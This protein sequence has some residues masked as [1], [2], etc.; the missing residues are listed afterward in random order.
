M[1]LIR[2][3]TLLGMTALLAMAVAASAASAA[4][5]LRDVTTHT[6]VAVNSNVN[7]SLKAGTGG[8]VLTGSF[9]GVTTTVTC[10][11]SGFTGKVT[12]NSGGTVTGDMSTLTFSGCTSS[13]FGG[14]GACT[15][16]AQNV[17]WTGGMTTTSTTSLSVVV[18]SN[19]G[20]QLSGA[21]CLPFGNTCTFGASQTLTPSWTN[22]ANGPG[23]M[24]FNGLTVTS[25]TCGNGTWTA[26]YQGRTGSTVGAGNGL[27]LV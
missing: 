12:T 9:F 13:F 21:S 8:S 27:E 1:R 18:P 24:R 15:V 11:G 22:V 5:T 2:K 25:P 3:I 26:T 20:V 19:G 7:G 4:A 6:A 10:T 23:E 17:P 16:T 14:G